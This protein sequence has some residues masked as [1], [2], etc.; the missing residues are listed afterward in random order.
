MVR[1]DEDSALVKIGTTVASWLKTKCSPGAITTIHIIHGAGTS[2][3]LAP[4]G[5]DGEDPMYCPDGYGRGG[6]WPRSFTYLHFRT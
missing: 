5:A 4:F 2:A 6:R 1:V 3:S